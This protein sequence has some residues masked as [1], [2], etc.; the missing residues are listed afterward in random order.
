MCVCVCVC[1]PSHVRSCVTP[2]TV[3]RQDHLS[4]RFSSW[5]YWS[6]LP[7]PP[8]GNIYPYSP[9]DMPVWGQGVFENVDTRVNC[10]PSSINLFC[11]WIRGWALNTCNY[12]TTVSMTQTDDQSEVSRCVVLSRG[13]VSVVFYKKSWKNKAEKDIFSLNLIPLGLYTL[14]LP[15]FSTQEG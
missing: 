15:P 5:E 6:G 7:C 8:S 1:V 10:L 9:S 4:M 11:I 2:W 14:T 12:K 3:A 13:T